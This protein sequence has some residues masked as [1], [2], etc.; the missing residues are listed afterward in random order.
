MIAARC[1]HGVVRGI[2]GVMVR[3]SAGSARRPLKQLLT[4]LSVG[5]LLVAPVP[6]QATD[7]YI[8]PAGSD[9]NACT[10]S[11][12]CRTW[13]RADNLLT[14]P[15]DTLYA[16]SGTYTGQAG[17]WEGASGTSS[18]PVTFRNY[19]GE[20]PVFEGG[21]YESSFM[22]VAD[23]RD[24]T[25]IEGLTVQNYKGTAGI[26]IGYSG[27]GS[28]YAV[29][30]VIRAMAF[31]NMG[32]DV[33]LEHAIYLSYGN[34]DVTIEDNR[35]FNTSG[36]A[37][38]AW[39][40]PGVARARVR[41]NLI[42]GANWGILFADGARDVQVYSNTILNV[43]EEC[44]RAY[45]S[46]EGESGDL[47]NYSPV[48]RNNINV[49]C[50]GIAVQGAIDPTIT[51]NH[52]HHAPLSGTSATT[53]DPLFVNGDD[54]RL[55]VGSPAECCGM[56]AVDAL[57]DLDSDAPGLPGSVVT[58]STALAAARTLLTPSGRV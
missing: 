53:G 9:A 23:G 33:S 37:I 58:W 47:G 22:T 10:Q 17:A 46:G 24:Y 5:L 40:G 48:A 55:R 54:Y 34:Q 13:M 57:E 21:G 15:G 7:R 50:Q 8:S 12:P 2:M 27:W 31:R 4:V 11:A 45:P 14:Q 41:N 49:N 52:F 44:I 39:H 56:T 35:I 38:H 25:V 30:N 19:P 16:R 51:H 43:T 36:A 32:D 26:W 6:A 18:A 29:G 42:V 28:D 3:S 20:T 1:G